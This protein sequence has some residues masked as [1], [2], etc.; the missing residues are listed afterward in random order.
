M[1]VGQ[2]VVNKSI[3][4]SDIHWAHGNPTFRFTVSGT[5][6]NGVRHTYQ[7]FVEFRPGNYT[8][9]GNGNAILSVTF[10][11]VPTGTYEITEAKTIRYSFGSCARVTSN[12]TEKG[13]YLQ[14]VLSYNKSSGTVPKAEGTFYN[15]HTQYDQY[16]HTDVSE[17]IANFVVPQLNPQ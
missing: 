10:N 2:I 14:A 4:E 8:K 12:V 7:D 16:S 17:N 13:T 5:D 9:D 6:T 11:G 15:N 1:P 3:K